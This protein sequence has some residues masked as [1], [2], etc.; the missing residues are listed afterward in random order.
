MRKRVNVVVLVYVCL[1]LCLS[2]CL[3]SHISHLFVL[4]I[5]SHT[6]RTVE[7]K[8]WN[9][10]VAEFQ[11]SLHWKPYGK[12]TCALS[13]LRAINILN[14]DG[15]AFIRYL[16]EITKVQNPQR[17]N[18]RAIKTLTIVLPH[19]RILKAHALLKRTLM[20]CN[21]KYTEGFSQ[22]RRR[23]KRKKV[24]ALHQVV[25][26]VVF[27]LLLAFLGHLQGSAVEKVKGNVAAVPL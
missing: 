20:T 14:A 3:L 18:A 16:N 21:G 13:I 11:H 2:V 15:S 9:C 17:K 4:K 6:Q 26:Q 8:L 12:H 24:A 25:F 23:I 5:L 27:S 22:K 10:A 1:S 7:V 19:A